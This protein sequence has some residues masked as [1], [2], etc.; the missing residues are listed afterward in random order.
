MPN[1]PLNQLRQEDENGPKMPAIR[2]EDSDEDDV[3][4]QAPLSVSIIPPQVREDPVYNYGRIIQ[5]N[6][7]AIG[8]GY[9]NRFEDARDALDHPINYRVDWTA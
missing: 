6:G 4:A 5:E 3:R 1:I 9:K 8:I 7:I 2:E